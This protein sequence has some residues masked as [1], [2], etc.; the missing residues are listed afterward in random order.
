M[1]EEGKFYIILY[2]FETVFS[3]LRPCTFGISQITH[4]RLLS[5]IFIFR[6]INY[7]FIARVPSIHENRN[8]MI[9]SEY[10]GEESDELV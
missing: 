7:I 2:N 8:P 5:E 1:K 3:L 4:K 10:P 6:Q 9:I